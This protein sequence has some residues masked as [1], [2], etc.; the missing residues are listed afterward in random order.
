MQYAPIP[1]VEHPDADCPP[2]LSVSFPDRRTV[3]R[4][5]ASSSNEVDLDLEYIFEN[6]AG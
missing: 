4:E 5:A 1:H 2:T 6:P 3:T